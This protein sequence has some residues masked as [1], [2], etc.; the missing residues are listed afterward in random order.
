MSH[1]APVPCVHTRGVSAIQGSA[2]E[3]FNRIWPFNTQNS[4]SPHRVAFPYRSSIDTIESQM[5][6]NYGLCMGLAQDLPL[7]VGGTKLHKGTLR[8]GI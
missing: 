1:L 7:S 2:L 8:V 4:V 5:T 6:I 3:G